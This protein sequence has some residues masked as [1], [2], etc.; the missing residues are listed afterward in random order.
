MVEI[1]TNL[2]AQAEFQEIK[3]K[4][5]TERE[6]GEGRGYSTMWRKYKRRVLLA[7]SSQAFAQLVRCSLD[8]VF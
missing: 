8:L 6:L 2:I 4:V 5:V 1:P 3:E 7:M